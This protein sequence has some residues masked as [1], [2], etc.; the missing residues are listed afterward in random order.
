[1]SKDKWNKKYASRD[2]DRPA[3]PDPTF[4]TEV[5][6][7]Q[8]GRALDLAA[9]DGRHALYLASRGWTVT[10]VDFSDVAIDRGRRFEAA[11]GY[12]SI[13][14]I[15]ADLADYEPE[16]RAYELTT[17]MFLHVPW[18]TMEAVIHRAEESVAPGGTFLLLGHDRNNSG[19]GAGGPQDPEVLYTPEAVAATLAESEWKL[20]KVTTLERREGHPGEGLPA[21]EAPLPA[22]D[23]MVRARRLR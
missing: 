6:R 7:L 22:L 23:C 10:A 3:D 4:V 17:I 14:W 19:R 18:A 9:G 5:D 20:E 15:Q 12:T 13:T 21:Q 16:R 1:M 2:M 8:P 11:Q